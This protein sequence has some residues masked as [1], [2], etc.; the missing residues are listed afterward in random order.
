MSSRLSLFLLVLVLG[1]CTAQD[2]GTDQPNVLVIVADDLGYADIGAYNDDTFYETPHID[3]LARRGMMFTDGYAANPVCSPSRYSLLTGRAPSRE[4]HTDWFCGDRT[5]RFRHARYDCSMDTTRVTLGEAFQDA[6]YATWF[7]GKWHLGP[8]SIHWPAHQ[9]FDV[10]KGG[11]RA[12]SPA[13][14]GADGYFSPYDNPRLS[15]GPTG[16]YLPFRLADEAEQ[17][18]DTH[19]DDPF[20]ALLSFYEVHNPRQAPDS[21]VQKYRRKRDRLNLDAKNEFEPIEVGQPWEEGRAQKARVVQGHPVYAAMVDALDHSVG[22]VLEALSER[23]LSD[24]TVVV[25]VSDNGGLSTAEGHNTSNRPLRGGKGWV[26]EGGIR[27]PYVIHWP[28]VTDPGSTTDVPAVTTDL[29]PTLLDAA[30]LQKR[31]DEHVDGTSLAPILKDHSALDRDAL[32]WHY[33]HYSN[34]GGFPG[35][36]VRKGPWKLVEDYRD[37]SVQLFNLERDLGE[38]NDVAAKHPDRVDRLRSR[39]HDWYDRVGA[40]FLRSKEDGPAPWRPGK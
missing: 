22:Q 26:Y 1:G 40:R 3:S 8:D 32:F 10:N 39:L 23:G 17:F 2:R 18:I 5:G 34:Q 30:G 38:Q 24:N 36:A 15:D 11:W 13:A 35:G 31:P 4:N 19:R 21:L 27:V 16:E 6:G 7:G 14:H 28:G 20:F 12:G 25:F 33:P 9:G 37:G 29:Y